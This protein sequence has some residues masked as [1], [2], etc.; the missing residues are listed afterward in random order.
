MLRAAAILLFDTASTLFFLGVMLITRNVA[1]ADVFEARSLLE[2]IAA[3]TIAS[4]RGRGAAVK[5][6]RRCVTELGMPGAVLPAVIAGGCGKTDE[7]ATAAVSSSAHT[8]QAGAVTV[9]PLPGT[10]DAT[11]Q[12]QISFLGGEIHNS[13]ASVIQTWK[14]ICMCVGSTASM[15]SG[16]QP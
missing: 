13:R 5:E 7:S 11:A 8:A 9:S 1:L 14:Q 2:P 6:L 10:P 4:A 16:I 3:R 12:T 15:G